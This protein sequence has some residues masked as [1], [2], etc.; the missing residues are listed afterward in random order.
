[1]KNKI[2][3]LDSAA[4]AAEICCDLYDA[5]LTVCASDDRQLKIIYPDLKNVNVAFGDNRIIINQTKRPFALS[6]QLITL[7]VPAHIVPDIKLCLKRSPVTFEGGIYGDLSLNG[8]D[9]KLCISNCSFASFEVIGGDIDVY[10]KEITVKGNLFAQLGKG[11]VLA[12]NSFASR[13]E[14]RLKSGNLGLVNLNCKECVFEALKGNITA[15]LAGTE[16]EYNTVLRAK[17]GTFNRDNAEI[18]NAQKSVRAYTGKG[19]IMLDFVGERVEISEAA[20]S[21]EAVA[22]EA[23]SEGEESPVGAQAE[24]QPNEEKIYE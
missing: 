16:D 5:R 11:N 2:L 19:N 18:E 8:E 7:C 23:Q 20:L 6:R 1:M 22:A 14:C 9:G 24:P 15:T 10:L 13:A 3:K 17:V 21:D 12:E 4:E